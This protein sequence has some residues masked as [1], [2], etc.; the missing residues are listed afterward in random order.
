MHRKIGHQEI[1]NYGKFTN[2]KILV[3]ASGRLGVVLCDLLP[4]PIQSAAS[5]SKEGSPLPARYYRNRI[6]STVQGRCLQPDPIGFDAGDV[7][8]YRYVGNNAVNYTD[9]EGLCWSSGTAWKD[10]RDGGGDVSLVQTGC[11]DIVSQAT[12]SERDAA[13]KEVEKDVEKEAKKMKCPGA[14]AK[15]INGNVKQSGGVN[16]NVFWIGGIHLEMK[17]ECKIIP[18]CDNCEYSYSCTLTSMMNDKFE[19]PYDLLNTGWPI[20]GF[21]TGTPYNVSH[22][23]TDYVNGIG[24]L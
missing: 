9:P 18:D 13:K 23:W 15:T 11:A 7:N 2:Q 3:G 21:E 20:L 19:K 8:W 12:K 24:S 22:T 6:Y 10:Y 17:Y 5:A 4:K 1:E 14:E 16:S